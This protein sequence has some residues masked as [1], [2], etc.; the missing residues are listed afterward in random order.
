MRGVAVALLTAVLL[1]LAFP[2]FNVAMLAPVALTPLLVAVARE[3][4]PRRRFLAGYIAGVVY[5]FG[6]CYW[7]ERVLANYG[8]LN[9]ALAWLSFLLFCLIK[10]I[11]MGVFALAAG[12]L[13]RRWWAVPAVAGLWVAIE[14]THG[15]LGFAWL[16]LGNAGIDMGLPMRLAPYTSVYGISFVFAMTSAALALAMLRRPRLQLIWLVALPFLIFLPPL[17]DAQRG[18]QTAVLVQ[19]DLSEDTQWTSD[20]VDRMQRNLAALSL[21]TVMTGGADRPALVVWPEVPAPLYYDAD[22]RFRGYVEDLARAANTYLLMGVVAHTPQGAPLNSAIL[23]SPDGKLIT[24]YDKVNLVPFGEFVPWPFDFVK[25]ITTEAGDFT[26]GKQVVVSPVDGHMIGAFICYE[27]VFPNFV[28]RFV[29]GGAE[30]L[31]NISNDG[32]FGRSAAREQH[33]EIAR[34]RAAENRRWILRSTNDGITGTIDPAGRLRGTLPLYLEAASRNGF[35]YLQALTFYT[36]YGDWFP[37]LCGLLAI[38][39]LAASVLKPSTHQ[40]L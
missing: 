13:M 8:G 36:R 24:R 28:R 10:A 14:S 23:I 4:R 16:A 26:P 7:I 37:I 29:A 38:V 35:T 9:T 31:F 40:S 39:L 34:M 5:W 21:R 30:V 19:P 15:S 2:N 18:R 17:P 3:P 22:P 20:S 27:S 32:Y 1:V 11:H 6:V 12:I 33:L 25:R